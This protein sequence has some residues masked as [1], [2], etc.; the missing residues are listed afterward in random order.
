A[1]KVLTPAVSDHAFVRWA[2]RAQF[3]QVLEHGARIFERL[4]PFDHSKLLLV[5]GTWACIGSAN[6]DA[7]SLRL[8]F[9]LNMEVY[10]QAFC[11][12]LQRVFDAACAQ[13]CEVDVQQLNGRPLPVKLRDGIARLF[14]PIL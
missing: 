11:A 10:D 3:W 4:G 7:R 6:W 12:Q 9:E 5:D 2:A 13:A 14:T 8:N 1:V